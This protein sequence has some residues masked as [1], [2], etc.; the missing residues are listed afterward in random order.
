[1]AQLIATVF[2]VDASVAQHRPLPVTDGVAGGEVGL[3]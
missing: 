1:M 3:S 2:L